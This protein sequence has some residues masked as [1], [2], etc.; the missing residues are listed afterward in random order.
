MTRSLSLTR[1]TIANAACPLSALCHSAR[2]HFYVILFEGTQ[3]FVMSN[4]HFHMF[5]CSFPPWPSWASGRGE[6]DDHWSGAATNQTREVET[7]NGAKPTRHG[8]IMNSWIHEP[9]H[10]MTPTLHRLHLPLVP[11]LWKSKCLLHHSTP[12]FKWLISGWLGLPDLDLPNV[13]VEHLL[14]C[15]WFDL[16][17]LPQW[18]S[19]QT[20]NSLFMGTGRLVW[21][22]FR[23]W[24]S[25]RKGKSPCHW[26]PTYCTNVVLA[27][28]CQHH[29]HA[30]ST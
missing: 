12:A 16:C 6:G 21:Q 26:M 1:F 25:G 2:D 30:H 7:W 14:I 23:S 15:W 18:L 24:Q 20:R 13:L 9:W 17:H 19:W 29:V 4:L 8:L 22:Y 3:L 10:I 27:P 11:A 28:I 5:P